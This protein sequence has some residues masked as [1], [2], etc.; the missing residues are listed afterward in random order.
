MIDT[1][2]LHWPPQ[3]PRTQYPEYSRFETAI[4]RA[5]D[6]VIREL[7]LLGARDIVASLS[8]ELLRNGDIASRQWYSKVTGGSCLPHASW[9]TEL[10]PVPSRRV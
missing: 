1:F 10:Y 2:P 3:W 4:T 5:R 6:G 7:E 9:R 8:T